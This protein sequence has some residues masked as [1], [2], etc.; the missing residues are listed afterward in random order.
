[1]KRKHVKETTDGSSKKKTRVEYEKNMLNIEK[2]TQVDGD[3]EVAKKKKKKRDQVNEREKK[4]KDGTLEDSIVNSMQVTGKKYNNMLKPIDIEEK[5]LKVADNKID[6]DDANSYTVIKSE[7]VEAKSKTKKRKKKDKN[8]DNSGGGSCER[9]SKGG[10]Q[11][12]SE[13]SVVCEEGA[14]KKKKNTKDKNSKDDD[15]NSD[16]QPE[17]SAKDLAIEYL[18][19]WKKHRDEWK[20]QKVRQVWLLNHMYKQDMVSQLS[21]YNIYCPMPPRDNSNSVL[22]MLK[23]CKCNSSNSTQGTLVN[24]LGRLSVI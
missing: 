23:H 13:N 7:T 18:K 12:T 5:D 22:Y 19:Q 1:M 3:S 21:Q 20:F 15:D 8:Q 14:V 4:I 17:K 24:F 9:E 6:K 2:N 16:K 11:V 10:E